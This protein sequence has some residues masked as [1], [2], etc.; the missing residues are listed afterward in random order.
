MSFLKPEPGRRYAMMS[1]KV[2]PRASR[3]RMPPV[4]PNPVRE[5]AALPATMLLPFVA[6]WGFA[7]DIRAVSVLFGVIDV[8]LAWWALGNLDV[9]RR[10]RLATTVFFAFGTV[11]WYAAQLG[12]TW[13]FAHVVAVTFVLLAIGISLGAD[14]RADEVGDGPTSSSPAGVLRA[15]V[16]RPFHLLDLLDR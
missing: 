1:R 5:G 13:F 12:T 6:L 9:S 16:R 15:A 3:T 7:T 4:S 8:G 10:V 14:P 11:F 2:S